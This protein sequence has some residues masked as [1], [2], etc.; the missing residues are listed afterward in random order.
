MNSPLHKE[1]IRSQFTHSYRRQPS[2]RRQR[3]I[4]IIATTALIA[5]TTAYLSK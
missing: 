5:L 1:I 4:F 2:R 3:I